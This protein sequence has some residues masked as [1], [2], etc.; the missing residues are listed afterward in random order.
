MIE[1]LHRQGHRLL[2]ALPVAP[3]RGDTAGHL[4]QAVVAPTERP[5]T[6]PAIGAER[7]IDHPG[8]QRA[9][10]SDA[11]A[12]SLQRIGAIA[13]DQ[14]VCR[15]QQRLESLAIGGAPEV[16]SRAAL[17]QGHLG[18]LGRFVPVGRI[19]PQHLGAQ[20]GQQAGGDRPGED[21]GQVEDADALQRTLWIGPPIAGDIRGCPFLG[22]QGFGANGLSLGMRLPLRLAAQLRR[23]AARR[24]DGRLQVFARPARHGLS[25]G[26]MAIGAAQHGQGALPVMGR[27][28]VQP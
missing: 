26:V 23:A 18:C 3:G 25:H 2:T 28:G 9:T 8:I 22:D 21:A 24:D 10:C 17:A 19:D 4:H 7:N 6:A 1:R 11:V 27:I 20:P 12:Q 5:G 13:V 15:G 16:Q 14:D